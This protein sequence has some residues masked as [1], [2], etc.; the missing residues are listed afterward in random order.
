MNG[1]CNILLLIVFLLVAGCA[2]DSGKAKDQ[3]RENP[4]K[5]VLT[6]LPGE[7]NV[8][9][10]AEVLERGQVLMSYS[11]CFT[12]HKE[13]DKKL[14]PAFSDIAARYPMNK[15][16]IDVL[17][18]RIVLGTKGMWGNVMMPPHPKLSEQD[19]EAMV[20]YILSLKNE[21]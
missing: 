14:G 9:P 7:V 2:S 21:D 4:I 20:L 17:V 1:Y 18:K 3:Q 12:C 8:I 6:Q 5:T 10:A 13:N 16:Y 19:A 15:G 11:D